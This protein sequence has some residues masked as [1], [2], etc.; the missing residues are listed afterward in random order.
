MFQYFA[1]NI[2]KRSHHTSRDETFSI[3]QKYIFSPFTQNFS[4]LFHKKL[5]LLN[6]FRLNNPN[7]YS[8]EVVQHEPTLGA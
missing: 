6:L 8:Q 1:P 2:E 5:G 7:I 3:I 4:T